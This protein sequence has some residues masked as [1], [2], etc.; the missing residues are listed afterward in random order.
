MAEMAKRAEIPTPTIDR[1]IART[2]A[3]RKEL[4][5]K[6]GV[7]YEQIKEC[8]LAMLNGAK[9]S[10]NQSCAIVQ[11]IGMDK[12]QALYKDRDFLALKQEAQE[13]GEW[14]IQHA[15]RNTKSGGIINCR[16][17]T[18]NGS[19]K[20][21]LA[22]LLQGIESEMLHAALKVYGPRVLVIQHDGFTLPH[23]VNPDEVKDLVLRK[24]GFEMPVSHQR[25]V[26]EGLQ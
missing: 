19:K 8:L 10:L 26:L 11:S 21:E 13:V 12:A 20:Q 2:P 15:P 5:A 3:F 17:K 23:F 24:T 7:S 9:K 6:L 16:G 4:A 1:Y 14:M 18:C 25:L 22:H